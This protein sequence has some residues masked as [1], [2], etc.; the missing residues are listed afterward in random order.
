V[1]LNLRSGSKIKTKFGWKWNKNDSGTK[2]GIPK[3]GSRTK[4]RNW[5]WK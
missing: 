1:E 4:I 3:T 5:Q 2:T